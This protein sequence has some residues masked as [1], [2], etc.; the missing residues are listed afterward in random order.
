MFFLVKLLNNMKVFI[1]VF[2]N[3]PYYSLFNIFI[4]EILT[5]R[6]KHKY[7]TFRSLH[8]WSFSRWNAM[9]TVC[10]RKFLFR[11]KANFSLG[12]YRLN[13][14]FTLSYWW[15]F[16]SQIVKFRNSICSLCLSYILL[17]S[18]SLILEVKTVRV[19][20]S[21]YLVSFNYRVQS[22]WSNS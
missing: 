12:N 7:T 18:C 17:S 1:I 21:S 5:H 4:N 6:H 10:R 15:D 9:A 11:F 3:N 13:L 20:S 19:K 2:W 14:F 16:T 22:L 8:L